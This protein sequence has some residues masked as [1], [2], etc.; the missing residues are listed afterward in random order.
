MTIAVGRL[1]NRASGAVLGSVFAVTDRLAL[2]AFHC[3]SD[4]HLRIIKIRQVRCQWEHGYTDAAVADF[5]QL[6]DVALLRL[7]D[8]LPDGLKPIGLVSEAPEH[9]SYV[10]PGAPEDVANAVFSFAASGAITWR[11]T[12]RR[13]GATVIQ[14]SSRE[15]AAGLSLHGLSGAPVLVGDP[16][17]AVGVVRWNPESPDR[18]G[19]AA[20]GTIYAAPAAEVLRK[21]PQVGQIDRVSLQTLLG[22]IADREHRANDSVADDIVYFLV[23]SG[24]GVAYDDLVVSPETRKN[25]HRR[26]VIGSATTV[27]EVRADLRTDA[28]VRTG[29]RQLSRFLASHDRQSARRH[30]GVLTDGADWRLYH[31]ARGQMVAVTC[32]T[33]PAHPAMSDL[34]RLLRWLE[35]LLGTDRHLRP[36]PD[37][38]V[39]KLGANSPSYALDIAELTEIYQTSRNLSTVQVKRAVWAKLLTTASGEHFTDSDSLFVNHT[40]LV[41]MAKVIG[42]AIVGFSVGDGSIDAETMMSGMLFSQAQIWGVIE[43]D[44][45]DWIAQAAGGQEFIHNLARRVTRFAWDQVEHDVMK[46]LY[47]S[48]I[49]QET[50]HHLGEYYTPDWLAEEIISSCVRDPLSERVLDASCGSGTFLFHAV[51]SYVCHAAD[52]GM[53][54][55]DIVRTVGEHVIGFDVHPVAVTLARVTYLLAIGMDRLRA[56]SRPEFTVPVYLGDS[57]RWGQETTL[58]SDDGLSV[59]TELDEETFLNDPRFVGRRDGRPSLEFPED[60]VTDAHRFDL[61]I[62]ELADLATNRERGSSVPSLRGTF[63]RLDVAKENRATLERTFRVMCGLHDD[64][65]DH[66]WGYYVRNLARPVWLGR[67]EHRVDVLVG[68]PPWLA[69]R[70]MTKLQKGSFRTMTTDRQLWVG[71]AVATN[72]DLS[73]LFVVRCIERYLRPG[74]RFGYVMPLAALTRNQYIAFRAGRFSAK[75]GETVDVAFER[76]WD[77]H[78]VKP[79]FFPQAV[80][81]V[82]GSRCTPTMAV[83]PL[84]LPAL[85]WS[86]HFATKTA[87]RGEALAH[88]SKALAELI[89]TAERSPYAALFAEGATV[90]PRFLFLVDQ[91]SGGPLGTGANR[92]AVRSFRRARERKPWKDL[93]SLAGTV[94]RRFVR[95]VYLGDSVMPFRCLPPLHA[96]VPWDGQRLL[97]GEDER[98]DLY[99]GLSR[100]WRQAESIWNDNRTNE[101]YSLARRLDYHRGL[102]LQFSTNA[103]RVVYPKSGAYLAAAIVSDVEAIIDHKLYWGPV[104]SLDEARYLTAIL[105]STTLTMAVRPLQAR[106]QHNPRDFDKYVFQLP[107]PSYNAG[108]GIHQRLVDLA[109]HAETVAAATVLP[110]TRFETQRRHVRETLVED[111]AAVEIDGLVKQLLS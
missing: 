26:I 65:R 48:I 60:I 86:G 39:T 33:I 55:V 109:A 10:A 7:V 5:D 3:V 101:H 35:S 2:T 9:T 22:R 21:W 105:N 61:L 23:G 73:A 83:A 8:R 103:Y 77:L 64:E 92:V 107:I 24:I 88:V 41:A 91:R 1:L 68:N 95:P 100:W 97:S 72:Q 78:L 79:A 12:R 102:T 38:I 44:F 18:P 15:S 96:V 49:P 31:R 25:D 28:M 19:I 111:G 93:P 62:N 82:F 47:E 37:E 80:G 45:F 17:R 14:L 90:T 46:V 51:R 59:P 70:Y 52:A 36:T 50:R 58:W 108:D 54:D 40:L 104:P 20:G 42:H 63:R 43:K 29:E 57:L 34:D 98:L 106:G 99:P 53:P 4:Q 13:G 75:Q 30:V 6:N 85:V 94:E 74:G 110:D 27:L 76:P 81:A 32:I 71:S 56:G 67:P 87:S 11:R 16:R 66:I 89:P 69:Y 84:N